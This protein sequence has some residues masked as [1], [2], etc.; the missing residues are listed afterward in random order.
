MKCSILSV[1][2]GAALDVTVESERFVRVEG[3]LLDRAAEV[4]PVIAAFLRRLEIT[5]INEAVELG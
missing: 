4:G 2:P 5:A 3:R 1:A